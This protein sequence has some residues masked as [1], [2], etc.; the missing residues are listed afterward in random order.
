[1]PSSLRR[2]LA[3]S[4]SLCGNNR[5]RHKRTTT[6][7]AKFGYKPKIKF[8]KTFLNIFGFPT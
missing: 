4:F 1:L 2:P 6:S 8:C 5:L 7:V 3:T